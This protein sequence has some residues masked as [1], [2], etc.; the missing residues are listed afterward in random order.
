MTDLSWR[1][2]TPA[3]AGV[4][5]PALRRCGSF[6]ASANPCQRGIERSANG[7]FSACCD[8]RG[9]LS[10]GCYGSATADRVGQQSAISG[11]SSLL[12]ARHLNGGS[13]NATGHSSD[14]VG[15]RGHRSVRRS[16]TR[17]PSHVSRIERHYRCAA[18]IRGAVAMTP[19]AW[20][21]VG[22]CASGRTQW[23][24]WLSTDTASR[25][26]SSNIVASSKKNRKPSI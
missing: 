17:E 1:R 10:E 13:G 24:M 19:S 21:A 26:G 12:S 18:V 3:R 23:C 22:R 20:T 8:A 11:R 9:A 7:W 5:A 14:V 25:R 6:V 4:A 2:G 16:Q 15:A